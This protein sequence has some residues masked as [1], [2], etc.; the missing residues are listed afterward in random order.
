[1][2]ADDQP[3][4]RIARDVD[5]RAERV[6]RHGEKF[7]DLKTGEQI[8]LIARRVGGSNPIHE[9]LPPRMP[10]ELRDDLGLAPLL[11]IAS[12]GNLP[13]IIGDHEAIFPVSTEQHDLRTEPGRASGIG[14]RSK[15]LRWL[16]QENS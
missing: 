7:L 14:S 16:Y 3:P 1:M 5:P 6:L 9:R 11:R 4:L 12:L 8:E 15:G 13:R 10:V 2:I